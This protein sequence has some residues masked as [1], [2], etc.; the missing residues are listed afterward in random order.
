VGSVAS[1]STLVGCAQ[2]NTR[3]T[4]TSSVHLDPVCT[5]TRGFEIGTSDV[6]LDCRGATI[7]RPVGVT[8]S[9]GIRSAAPTTT[10]L[11]DITVRN[12][13]VSG[14]DNDLRIT[15]TGFKDLAVGSEYDDAFARILIEHS[16]FLD[17][18][19]SGVF[20]DGFVTGVTMDHT[21]VD[22]AG[23]VG[24]YLEAGSTGTTISHSIVTD[25][26]YKD[27]DAGPQSFTFGTTTVQYVST[28]REGISVDGSSGNTIR[29]NYIARNAY[30]GIFLYKNCGE[31]ASEPGHWVRNY[32]STDNAIIG[33]VIEDE[34]NAIWVASRAAE[35]QQFMDCSD[36]PLVA[37][38]G[39]LQMV[40]LDPVVGTVV[41]F[42]RLRRVTRGIR[43]EGDGTVVRGNEIN[44]TTHGV[45]V[46]TQFRTTVG[47][48][49]VAGTSILWNVVA[50]ASAPYSWAWGTSG[51]TF[52]GNVGNGRNAGFPSGA[53]PGTGPFLMVDHFV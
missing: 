21:L 3:I 30:G 48:T 23:A 25:S 44:A 42:N 31:N 13:T 52:T 34:P 24:I 49:P 47:S 22:R 29:D 5:Y 40:Y 20:I 45:F 18:R 17:S 36:T 26:G 6:T 33:N 19:N 14:F 32:G 37:N 10:A 38:P 4:I 2:A 50:G 15:R 27:I 9:Y 28:G 51:T 8:Q 41:E 7:A 12:C 39:G 35:N 43:I 1:D 53:Q 46:G 16:S 11:H